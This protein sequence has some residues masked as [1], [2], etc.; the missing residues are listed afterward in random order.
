MD[1][2]AVDEAVA[3][4]RRL[5]SKHDPTGGYENAA[6]AYTLASDPQ[7]DVGPVI[8][9]GLLRMAGSQEDGALWAADVL[10]K[11]GVDEDI[12]S[13]SDLLKMQIWRPFEY[14][15]AVCNALL[16]RSVRSLVPFAKELVGEG[17]ASR[18]Q[19]D[20]P[21][22]ALLAW[23]IFH[24]TDDPQLVLDL[25][26]SQL[27][28]RAFG[29]GNGG[30]L[31]PVAGL[32]PIDRRRSLWKLI[33]SAYDRSNELGEYVRDGILD[34]LLSEMPLPRVVASNKRVALEIADR[35]GGKV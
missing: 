14:R 19:D 21:G 1:E 6:E 27:Q 33:D 18:S 5:R 31:M 26:S 4:L 28:S 32:A 22:A 24:S 23:G 20:R 8:R 10:A 11:C 16:S 3:F 34:V 15:A 29:L 13:L 35:Y 2:K 7:P 17:L 25:V 9:A 12:R 30:L